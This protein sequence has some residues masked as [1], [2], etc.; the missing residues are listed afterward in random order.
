MTHGCSGRT[1]TR[2]SGARTSEHKRRGT[3]TWEGGVK[4]GKRS[5]GLTQARLRVATAVHPVRGAP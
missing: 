2:H 4:P 3:W 1:R 5:L